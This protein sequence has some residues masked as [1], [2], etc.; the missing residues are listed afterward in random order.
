MSRSSKPI[1]FD[2]KSHTAKE[3]SMLLGVDV[4]TVCRRNRK[5]VP[6]RMD[7][8]NYSTAWGQLFEHGGLSH[9]QAEWARKAGLSR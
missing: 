2:G 7:A 1:A 3:W 9:T 4:Q 5:G 6:L 8:P